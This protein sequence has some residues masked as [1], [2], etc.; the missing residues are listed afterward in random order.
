MGLISLLRTVPSSTQ[1]VFSILILPLELRGFIFQTLTY[2][3][4]I[5]MKEMSTTLILI[6]EECLKSLDSRF[7]FILFYLLLNLS[8]KLNYQH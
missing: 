4:M 6:F 8:I 5:N 3:G 7:N 2:W 1:M